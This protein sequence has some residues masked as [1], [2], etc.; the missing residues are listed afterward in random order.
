MPF[1]DTIRRT[2]IK[3][4]A[5]AVALTALISGV[6]ADPANGA[7]KARC[8]AS[9]IGSGPPGPGPAVHVRAYA[10]SATRVRCSKVH[11]L[12]RESWLWR[13]GTLVSGWTRAETPRDFNGAPGF[14]CTG[15]VYVPS[16]NFVENQIEGATET[17][18]RGSKSFHFTWG[19]RS[20]FTIPG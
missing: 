4:A 15:R 1:R 19:H 10:E 14:R 5:L 18:T 20:K 17:C 3:S 11:K 7:A 6:V 2:L 16:R 8:S 9:P 13:T 12:L